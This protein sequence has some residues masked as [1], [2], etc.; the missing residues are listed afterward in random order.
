MES[1]GFLQKFRPF[2]CYLCP[3]GTSE[4]ADISCGDPWYREIKEGDAGFSLA[5]VRTQRGREILHGAMDSGYVSLERVG[6]KIL[7][8]SQRNLLEKRKAIWGRLLAMKFFGIPTPRLVGF[9]LFQNWLKLPIPEKA[10]SFLGTVR[11]II[12]RKLYKPM[13]YNSAG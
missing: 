4:L 10:R 7:K 8:D 2:R 6:P 3:D 12:Q 11:R 1:W 9:Y 5:L 13:R